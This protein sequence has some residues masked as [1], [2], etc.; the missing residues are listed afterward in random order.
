MT[1]L[2]GAPRKYDSFTVQQAI[3]LRLAGRSWRSVGAELG[4]ENW[5]SLKRTANAVQKVGRKAGETTGG[6]PSAVPDP[7]P[8]VSP[9]PMRGDPSTP[10]GV[11]LPPARVHGA[12]ESPVLDHDRG[13]SP[14]PVPAIV[15]PTQYA[16][17]DPAEV[18]VEELRRIVEELLER[19][20]SHE[21]RP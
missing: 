3:D 1:H 11:S 14:F 7:S 18:V 13:D 16:G 19:G 6:V 2:G 20:R 5:E 17:M 4:V 9:I 10:S 8:P 21:P 12:A 15:I